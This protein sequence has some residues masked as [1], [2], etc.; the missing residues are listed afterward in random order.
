MKTGKV[1]VS[2]GEGEHLIVDSNVESMRIVKSVGGVETD[3]YQ[4]SDFTTDRFIYA[5]SGKSLLRFYHES[6]DASE[7]L[8]IAVE[9]RKVS[10]TV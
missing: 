3:A 2:L 1:S 5:P 10:D 4:Y 6:T 7:A 8:D 9:V